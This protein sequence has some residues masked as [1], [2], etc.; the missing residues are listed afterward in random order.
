MRRATASKHRSLR[1]SAEPRSNRPK[2]FDAQVEKVS[3]PPRVKLRTPSLP[4][5]WRRA[6]VWS[7]SVAIL[8]A[9]ASIYLTPHVWFGELFASFELHLGLFALAAAASLLFFRARRLAAVLALLGCAHI[10]PDLA[11]YLPP[12]PAA[13]AAD[14][15]PGPRLRVLSANVLQPNRHYSEIAAALRASDADVIG[16]LELSG[17]MRAEL[18][19]ELVAWPHRV[20][21]TPAKRARDKSLWTTALFSKQPLENVR[22]VQVFDCYAPLIEARVASPAPVTVRLVHLPRPG[23]RWRVEARNQALA[24][25]AR[26]FE[27]GPATLLIGD[28]NTTSSSPAFGELL[29]ATGLRDSRQGFGRNASWWLRSRP[30]ML[31]AG[32]PSW[33]ADLCSLRLGIAIDHA[34]TG[35]AL[36]TLERT[37]IELPFSDHAGVLAEF[38]IPSGPR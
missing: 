37:V 18:E 7:L 2:S 3:V 29:E 28:L 31:R 23:A 32:A 6:A 33:L 26:E 19:R 10:A 12:S 9:S 22:F 5:R 25:L 20:V 13:R 36:E 27:W 15:A 1:V 16:V 8:A 24:Q 11:L 17:P 34:L 14:E 21:A 38:S 30:S 4:Q 35:A